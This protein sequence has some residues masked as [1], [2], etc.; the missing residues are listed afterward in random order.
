VNGAGDV[1]KLKADGPADATVADPEF[2][3]ENAVLL[4]TG[5]LLTAGCW[6]G[7]KNTA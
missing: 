2:K 7:T 6:L 1:I 5:V 3:N 4:G